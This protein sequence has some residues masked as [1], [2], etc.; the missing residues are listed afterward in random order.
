[1]TQQSRSQLPSLSQ[2]RSRLNR[3]G[4]FF[5]KTQKTY[6]PRAGPKVISL[7][8]EP[9]DDLPKEKK[10][11]IES[12]TTDLTSEAIEALTEV[13]RPDENLSDAVLRIMKVLTELEIYEFIRTGR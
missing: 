10:M 7:V 6:S 8:S 4:P 11:K 2:E 3:L 9:T 5:T 12:T 13:C 1:M